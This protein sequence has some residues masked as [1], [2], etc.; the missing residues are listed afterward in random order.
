MQ[1]ILIFLS[2]FFI[3]T[4]SLD[5]APGFKMPKAKMPGVV[6]KLITAISKMPKEL[7]KLMKTTIKISRI[8]MDCRNSM[9]RP[10]PDLKMYFD[11]MRKKTF[12]LERELMVM[13][14][15]IEKFRINI[16]YLSLE[17]AGKMCNTMP[18]TAAMAM[19]YVGTAVAGMCGRVGFVEAKVLALLANAELKVSEGMTILQNMNDKIMAMEQAGGMT[20]WSNQE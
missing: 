13:Q 6:G 16:V 4:G 17:N 9:L 20:L 1:K 3:V 10:G 5:A 14:M 18:I 2:F 7:E 8:I 19:P 11:E 15:S 12:V